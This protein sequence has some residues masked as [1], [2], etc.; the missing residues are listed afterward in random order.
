MQ[1]QHSGKSQQN[2]AKLQVS[3]ALEQAVERVVWEHA[4]R[5]PDKHTAFL[6]R[7]GAAAASLPPGSNSGSFD[8]IAAKQTGRTTARRRQG[9][10]RANASVAA[11][12]G[13]SGDGG[14][15]A[16]HIG[17]VALRLTAVLVPPPLPWEQAGGR[18]A[19]E[20]AH[21]QAALATNTSVATVPA[22]A[23][24]CAA[25]CEQHCA[26]HG[27]S[28]VTVSSCSTVNGTGN[29]LHQLA[30][31]TERDGADGQ[32]GLSLLTPSPQG[33]KQHGWH[34][35]G[36][37]QPAAVK[38]QRNGNGQH[39]QLWQGLQTRSSCTRFSRAIKMRK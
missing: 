23:A 30:T 2:S 9:L 13:S 5:Q 34:V 37:Q 10:E 20:L 14:A 33:H 28:G 8:S 22:A 15:E 1:Q 7:V 6:R 24:C 18:E 25:P 21:A 31:S 35:V 17:P 36:E 38:G 16:V 27:S 4:A 3:A 29:A 12:R 11:S 32:E 19:E 26:A 39:M